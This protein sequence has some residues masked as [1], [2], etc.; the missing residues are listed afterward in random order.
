MCV[1]VVGVG[2]DKGVGAGV[3]VHV[4]A[5]VD[6][7][8]EVGAHAG[9]EAAQLTSCFSLVKERTASLLISELKNLVKI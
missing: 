5:G 3:V 6:V 7:G 4:D 8:E 9:E 2:V 1:L